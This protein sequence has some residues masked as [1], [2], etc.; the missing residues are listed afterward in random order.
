MPT[1][2]C[3]YTVEVGNE[4]IEIAFEPIDAFRNIGANSPQSLIEKVGHIFSDLY[5]DVQTPGHGK[6]DKTE[7]CRG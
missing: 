5:R 2:E 1:K 3:W 7:V 4:G 6:G